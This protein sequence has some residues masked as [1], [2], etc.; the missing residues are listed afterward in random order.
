LIKNIAK[1]GEKKVEFELKYSAI[2]RIWQKEKTL[3][4]SVFLMY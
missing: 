1:L 3:E 4:I 2:Y